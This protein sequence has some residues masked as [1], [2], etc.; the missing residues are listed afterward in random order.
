MRFHPQMSTPS[1]PELGTRL[2]ELDPDLERHP[3]AY[4]EKA[5]PRSKYAADGKSRVLAWTFCVA[6]AFSLVTFLSR[7]QARFSEYVPSLFSQAQA[8]EQC[9]HWFAA[10]SSSPGR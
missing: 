4:K 9:P 2:E 6:V 10:M 1:V 5:V 3:F 7:S 8:G